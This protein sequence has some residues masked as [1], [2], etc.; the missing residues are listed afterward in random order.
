MNMI[1]KLVVK[2]IHSLGYDVYKIPK[3]DFAGL[4][5]LGI[6]TILDIGANRGQ[7]AKRAFIAFPKTEI[8]CFE[9][10]K[11]AFEELDKWAQLEG[12]KRVF[13]FN[14][15]LGDKKDIKEMFL[16]SDH[17]DSS[18]MLQT[19]KSYEK[20]FS[21]VKNQQEITVEQYPL[22]IAVEKFVKKNFKKEIL[23]KMDVQGYENLVIE[24]AK[25][26][27]SEAKACIIEIVNDKFY[28]GQPDFKKIFSR[29]NSLEFKY[30]GNLEQVNDYKDGH[31]IYYDAIF[32]KI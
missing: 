25:K 16:H 11:P 30:Y 10:V 24:G 26:I 23:V 20:D 12:Q 19:T 1:K 18:S 32:L 2:I 14:I 13:A 22:D 27:L 9:P 17:D 4:D 28:E 7:F 15:A 31:I 5:K 3:V 6:K 8:F 21:F 29:M